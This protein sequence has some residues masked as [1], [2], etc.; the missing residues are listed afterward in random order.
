MIASNEKTYFKLGLLG[1][2]VKHSLSPK[3]HQAAL[4]HHNLDGEYK[5]YDVETQHLQA[6]FESTRALGLDG[7]NITIPHKE[8][9]LPFLTSLSREA[10][11][12]R[13]VNTIVFDGGGGAAGHNTDVYGFKHALQ[14]AGSVGSS[15]VNALS[16]GRA[17]LL[18]CGG[19][20]RAVLVGLIDL[21]FEKISVYGRN[22]DRLQAFVSSMQDAIEERGSGSGKVHVEPVSDWES[23]TDEINSALVVNA[24]PAG[25]T[26]E[27]LPDW[28]TALIDAVPQSCV[29]Y[30]LVYGKGGKETPVVE[31]ALA[32][33]LRA[34]SGGGMLVAQAQKAFE[35]W[36]GLTVPFEVME[37]SLR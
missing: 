18:G 34:F 37:S 20:A 8:A 11:R 15:S 13:A 29:V 3:L 35:L 1:H 16:G 14:H 21:G 4:S 10:S 23:S 17:L 2:P 27:A 25:Q 6:F 7:L 28:L 19:A 12:V 30:D 5:L 36:S 32:R 24:T 33:K 9:V 31:L 22:P 26:E